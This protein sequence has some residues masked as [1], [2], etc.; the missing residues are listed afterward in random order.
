MATVELVMWQGHVYRCSTCHGSNWECGC[1][2]RR[3]R[4]RYEFVI[5]T[6]I[7]L[8]VLWAATELEDVVDA[9]PERSLT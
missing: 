7:Y 2:M 4:N 9:E 6:R 8:G 5:W 3:H 1:V